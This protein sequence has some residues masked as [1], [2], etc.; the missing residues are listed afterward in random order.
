MSENISVL[1]LGLM[2]SALAGALLSAGHRVTVWNRTPAR[3]EPLAARGAAVA[4]TPGEAVAASPLVIACLLDHASVR[5]VLDGVELRGRVL[6][7]LTTGRPAE[8]RESASWATARGADHVSG[9][10]MAVPQMI[11]GPGALILYSGE[12]AAFDRHEQALAALAEP[13]WVGADPGMAPLLDLA[14]LT[15]MYGQ[16]AGGLAAAA[17]VRSAKYPLTE[18]TEDLLVPWL[19]AMAAQQPGWAAAM[20]AGDHRTGVSN[21][22]INRA[23]LRNL[24][25]AFAEQGVRADLLLPLQAIVERRVAR[26]LGHE[27]LSGLVLELEEGA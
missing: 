12:R 14:M 23:G 27:G 15:G 7:N 19:N 24:V 16:I 13:R 6:A 18:F 4:A 22:E 1:G 8:A 11:A 20:E 10:I 2:G 26:G 17:L 21:L 3:A 5:E 25:T 9:G